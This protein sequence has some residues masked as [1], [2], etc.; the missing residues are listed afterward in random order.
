[1]AKEIGVVVK[2]DDGT[3]YFFPTLKIG[4]KKYLE[5]GGC[6]LIELKERV[7][8]TMEHQFK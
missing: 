3:L 7:S 8:A 5:L 1:M 6:R 4:K 2:D